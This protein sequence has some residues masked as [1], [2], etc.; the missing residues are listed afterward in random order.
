MMNPPA[1]ITEE[2]QS[3]VVISGALPASLQGT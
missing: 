2:K 3:Q 1:D